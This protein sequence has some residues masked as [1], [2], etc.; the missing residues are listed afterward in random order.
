MRSLWCTKNTYIIFKEDNEVGWI[1]FVRWESRPGWYIED[2]S[3]GLPV[4][5]AD[6]DASSAKTKLEAQ[7][8]TWQAGVNKPYYVYT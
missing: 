4:S 8:Y 1:T 2:L 3:H 5:R 7:G 6:Y